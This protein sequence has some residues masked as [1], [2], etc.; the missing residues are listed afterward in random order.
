MNIMEFV[1]ADHIIYALLTIKDLIRT[2]LDVEEI[3]LYVI[4]YLI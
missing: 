2:V 4:N 3:V 1:N